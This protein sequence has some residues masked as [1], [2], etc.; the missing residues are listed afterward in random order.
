MTIAQY[1]YEQIHRVVMAE[2][3]VPG[4]MPYWS[5]A[6]ARA[7]VPEEALAKLDPVLAEP[8][9]LAA[10]PAASW[11]AELL[12]AW[13]LGLVH[14]RDDAVTI[15]DGVSITARRAILRDVRIDPFCALN[16]D[17]VLIKATFMGNHTIVEGPAVVIACRVRHHIS[18][19]P[20]VVVERSSFEP[21][22]KVVRFVHIDKSLIASH[23][24]IEGGTHP[25][26]VP[27]GA[28]RRML[29][30]RIGPD[31]WVGQHVSI[32]GGGAIGRG[33]VVATHTAI[34]RKHS[35]FVLVAGSPPREYPIDFNI[36][37]LS[38]D[39]A[40]A[41]GREQGILAMRLPVFGPHR[42]GFVSPELIEVDYAAHGY[43]RDLASINLIHFQRGVLLTAVSAM[44]PEHEIKVGFQIGA[45]VRFQLDISPPVPPALITT[46]TVVPTMFRNDVG[47][48]ML[49]PRAAPAMLA[50]TWKW[51]INSA[52]PPPPFSPAAPAV[53]VTEPPLDAQASTAILAILTGMVGRLTH[54]KAPVGPDTPFHAMGMDSIIVAE[55]SVSVEQQ[56]NVSAPDVFRN[57][58]VRKLARAIDRL[59]RG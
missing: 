47:A 49:V 54:Q 42:A 51:F 24:A 40:V 31:A 30:C 16:G 39:E 43:L 44:L 28:H 23:C 59:S 45:T 46:S 10:T 48:G 36:R 6:S 53:A 2:L 12:Y 20:L 26:Q 35:E 15:A 22:T 56:F 52:E 17:Q 13:K 7:Q 8:K 1:Y 41:E 5:S 32:T 37:G 33:S 4:L 50:A 21:F 29:G 27:L 58:T 25:E 19:G 11:I 34:M 14:F 18:L 9:A 3:E 57:N 38:P 55:L